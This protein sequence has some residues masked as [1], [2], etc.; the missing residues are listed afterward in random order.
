MV[1]QRIK[2]TQGSRDTDDTEVERTQNSGI[3]GYRQ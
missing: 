3:H 1:V 2:K